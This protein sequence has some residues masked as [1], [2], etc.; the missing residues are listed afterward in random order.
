MRVMEKQ[1][2]TDES[3][4]E[5]LETYYGTAMLNGFP[6]AMA[7]LNELEEL[8]EEELQQLAEQINL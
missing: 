2:N 5:K 7:D 4:R 3:I 1:E 6:A 8:S